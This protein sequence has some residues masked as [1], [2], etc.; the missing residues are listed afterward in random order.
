MASIRGTASP[1]F[2]THYDSSVI[3]LTW[4]TDTSQSSRTYFKPLSSFR[5][6]QCLPP[7]CSSR[8]LYC[9][10]RR[11]ERSIGCSTGRDGLKDNLHPTTQLHRLKDCTTYKY[12]SGRNG[13]WGRAGTTRSFLISSRRS[14]HPSSG[15]RSTRGARGRHPSRR[16]CPSRP[17]DR[18]DSLQAIGIT[19]D[20]DL[21]DSILART[22]PRQS[23]RN[24]NS[25]LPSESTLADG[26]I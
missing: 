15:G 22:H 25:F 10:P 16:V 2:L 13:S 4:G 26:Y 14:D 19:S 17:N 1:S 3:P 20:A 8:N 24:H 11:S 23:G 5:H 9:N 7:R 18:N 12:W 21:R 6:Q